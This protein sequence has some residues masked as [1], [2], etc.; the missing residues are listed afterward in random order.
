MNRVFGKKIEAWY[1]AIPYLGSSNFPLE[2]EVFES[3]NFQL[4]YD[5]TEVL[6]V[7]IF[8]PIEV[9]VIL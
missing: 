5:Y 4:L 1:G 2:L 7:L 6:I 3:H 8:P 9:H